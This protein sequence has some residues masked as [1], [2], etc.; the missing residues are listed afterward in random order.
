[1]RQ[2]VNNEKLAP[3]EHEVE[4]ALGRAGIY[5]LRLEIGLLSVVGCRLSVLGKN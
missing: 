5:M 1:V 3:G 4:L 2:L